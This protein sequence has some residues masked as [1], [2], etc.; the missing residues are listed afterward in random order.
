MTKLNF[1]RLPI[2]L[3]AS[4]TI[5]FALPAT[6]ARADDKVRNVILGIGAAIIANE[7]LKSNGNKGGNKRASGSSGG[8]GASNTVAQTQRFLNE[9]GYAAGPVDGQPGQKTRTAIE[10]FQRDSGYQITG[11]LTTE[12][13]AS[14]RTTFSNIT[15]P[16]TPGQVTRAAT[17]EAQLYLQKLGYS[18]GAP[19]GVWGPKSQ[20]ALDQYRAA[21]GLVPSTIALNQSDLQNLHIAVHGTPPLN[22]A[23][24]GSRNLNLGAGGLGSGGLG[25]GG[26]G[27]GGVGTGGLGS[28][29]LGSGQMQVGLSGTV[30]LGTGGVGVGGAGT[31]N[32]GAG[33]AGA[34]GLA[35]AGAFG[36]AGGL[37][38]GGVAN[39][40]LQAGTVGSGGA[41][42][43]GPGN[44]SVAGLTPGGAS[45][46]I[47]QSAGLTGPGN[48]SIGGA[49]PGLSGDVGGQ[50]SGLSGPG[51]LTIT[52]GVPAPG[53]GVAALQ[54]G[55]YIHIS[56]RP[57]DNMPDIKRTIAIQL[58]K[59]RT[60]LLDDPGELKK[61]FDRDHPT[62]RFGGEATALRLAFQA[63]NAIEKEDI[64]R[65]FKA[66]LLAEIQATPTLS[67]QNPIPIALYQNVSFGNYVD[68]KGLVVAGSLPTVDWDLKT[69]RLSSYASIKVD[70][71]ITTILPISREDARLL[72]DTAAQEKR[73][74]YRLVWGQLLS[75]GRDESVAQFASST[76][77]YGR[78]VPTTFQVD[79]VTLNLATRG[80]NVRPKVD[81]KLYTFALK[82]PSPQQP[83][84]LSNG[85]P[86]I[87]YLASKGVTVKHGHA[88]VGRGSNTSQLNKEIGAADPARI[89]SAVSRLAYL[90]W[91]KRN[92]EYVNRG[93]N[94]IV[95]ANALMN[96][97]EKRQFFGDGI[98][99]LPFLKS[100]SP[101]A[102]YRPDYR[103]VFPDEFATQ[104]AKQEFLTNIYP[105]FIASIPKWP[106]PII[107]VVGAR[108]GSY[109]FE[110]QR[111]AIDYDVQDSKNLIA[112]VA[113]LDGAKSYGSRWRLAS[114]DRIGPLPKHLEMDPD[115]ARALRNQ[116]NGRNRLYLGWTTS[117]DM[118][119]SGAT[120]ERRV[121]PNQNPSDNARL[122]TG[123]ASIK[124]IGLYLDPGLTQLLV[125]Y[126][127]AAL[128]FSPEEK[129]KIAET[130]DLQALPALAGSN[131]LL[132]AAVSLIGD[133]EVENFVIDSHPNVTNA[134]E[135]S[136]DEKREEVRQALNGIQTTNMW[137]AGEATLGQYDRVSGQ[138]PFDLERASKNL[139]SAGG[140]RFRVRTRTQLT[141]SR[142][143]DPMDVPEEVAREI[144]EKNWRNVE[145]FVQV[146]PV[147]ASTSTRGSRT[148]LELV[149]QPIAAIYVQRSL[150]EG[151]QVIYRRS[152]DSGN[153]LEHTFAASDF[154]E[155][156]GSVPFDAEAVN[157]LRVRTMSD[158][159]L[160]ASL[161][162]LMASTFQYESNS[163]TQP[164]VRFFN[165]AIREYSQEKLAAYKPRYKS[166]IKARAE[167]L[168]GLFEMTHFQSGPTLTCG[169]L[170][171][172][173]PRSRILAQFSLDTSAMVADVEAHRK[174]FHPDV[175]EPYLGRDH[176]MTTG[177]ID[178]STGECARARMMAVVSIDGIGLV[179]G[180]A[181][182]N[183]YNYGVR[184]VDFEVSD[185][186]REIGAD[187][188][189]YVTIMATASETRYFSQ[190]NLR[191]IQTATPVH[192]I[193]NTN[194]SKG[195]TMA[196]ADQ[197]AV[198]ENAAFKPENTMP[199]NPAAVS[200]ASPWPDVPEF[201]VANSVRDVV[202]LRIA[203]TFETADAIVQSEFDVTAVYETPRPSDN[204][205]PALGYVR[206]YLI[207][208]GLQ[209]ITLMSYSPEAPILAINRQM[210]RMGE[211]WPQ[212][213]IAG[214][215]IDKYA[216]PTARAS[217]DSS[218]VW[219]ASEACTNLILSPTGARKYEPLGRQELSQPLD[220][221]MVRQA[222][223]SLA[224]IG[225]GSED[226]LKSSKGC[227]EVMNYSLDL[228]G[229]VSG[230]HGFFTLLTDLDAIGNVEETLAPK[231]EDIEI[232]F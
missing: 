225:K 97:A 21:N 9:I 53:T 56:D 45:G 174:I 145:Y 149:L 159:E 139:M 119:T 226:F 192:V 229:Q 206:L 213:L 185:V 138:F 219:A 17:Y 11:T 151:Q 78:D 107:H 129:P 35:G 91:L 72:L 90:N 180:E 217:D 84:E 16:P 130:Q 28:G 87:E 29:E 158:A 126:D 169:T 7:V 168:G 187:G 109:D 104:D 74:M 208:G 163:R 76:G 80:Y 50:S 196:A 100:S 198:V 204:V 52:N 81:Q 215:L 221:R 146:K 15:E 46:G 92:D 176:V 165:S 124:E 33:G 94:F 172:I 43:S 207:D 157:L 71:P 227:G 148:E 99:N 179:P 42:L 60:S 216:E 48:L 200:D 82:Q 22:L 123:R 150:P 89:A 10:N 59:A 182:N 184:Q 181:F 96:D 194:S 162:A 20:G 155:L 111:F 220:Q 211:P 134:N 18:V 62:G 49:N 112:P 55:Q 38:T 136:V 140:S 14:L 108:L 214:S 186:N 105:K 132:K 133:P 173:E 224:T 1:T 70:L 189:E 106:V 190:Q 147:S 77:L 69:R 154:P 24:V 167:A 127:P 85:V 197:P 3:A 65:K 19:D 63:G 171:V 83:Q 228:L 175:T 191:Q 25:T 144:A 57:I 34:G 101:T 121:N 30:G 118:S 212:E 122:Q 205:S 93:Q 160:D 37:S 47:G 68:G 120:L 161:D 67:P 152:L 44:L 23:M 75:I 153:F 6:P 64:L 13:F 40:Q 195:T 177:L 231:K 117:L 102:D 8:G 170:S 39:G 142:L 232:K 199:E 95:V 230:H 131:Q 201:Q 66:D 114:T 26:L 218:M 2:A 5:A 58:A 210:L 164:S 32:I 135:F 178:P 88:L 193:A 103:P 4:A 128:T 143:F 137:L 115:N 61:W 113:Q 41:S 222:I 73:Q 51:N 27:M 166:W 223:G 31:G 203:D 183:W 141:D 86:V 156:K 12:Q 54:L 209:I 98:Q 79:G 188:V 116:M 110:N 125:P 36:S 202:G